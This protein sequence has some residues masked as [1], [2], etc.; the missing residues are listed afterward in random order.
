VALSSS[1]SQDVDGDTLS[2]EWTLT[3][4]AG[5]APRVIRQANPMITCDQNGVY[6]AKLTVTDPAGAKDSASVDIVA[7]NEP[8]SIVVTTNGPSKTFF[9]PGAPIAYTVQ[10]ADREDGN[11][12]P[13]QVSLSI[14]YVPEG[15]DVAALKQ[16]QKT[17]DATTRF[18]VAKALVAKYDCSFCHNRDNK[19]V[20]PTYRDLAGKYRPDDATLNQLTAKVKA[21]GSGVW[22]SVPMP[23]HPLVSVSEAKTILRYFLSANDPSFAL[24]PLTGNYTPTIPQDDSGRGAV[25]IHAVYTDKGAGRLPAQ[26][27]EALVVLRSPT[28]GADT[29]DVQS[30]VLPQVGRNSTSSAA[31]VPRS[32][33]YIAFKALD[34][35]GVTALALGAQAGGRA[36]GVGGTIEIHLDAVGGALVGQASVSVATP[37]AGSA[38]AR[39]AALAPLNVD[40]KPTGGVHDVY[41]VFKNERANPTQ[42]LMTL[43]TIRFVQ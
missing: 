14:D 15:F 28:L 34:L 16:G 26:T 3:S 8:P 37:P 36:G 25:V 7:G 21:G 23:S 10:V 17:V 24:L 6:T 41:F 35:T 11:I 39:A 29:A 1:G 22:G 13:G 38:A 4:S 33:G 19:T 27:A 31:I 20:G 12:V 32:N 30:G 42:P 2:Y 40:L 5:G 9:R 18:G 43:A